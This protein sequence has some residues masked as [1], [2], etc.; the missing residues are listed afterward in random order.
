MPILA[1][2]AASNLSLCRY[3]SDFNFLNSCRYNF[4]SYIWIHI[5]V[6]F[7]NYFT[8]FRINYIFSSIST[9]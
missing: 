9:N 1:L 6:V 3:R 4:F 7:N 8:I 5:S 2:N